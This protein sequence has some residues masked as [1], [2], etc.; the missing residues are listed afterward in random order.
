MR[1]TFMRG[2]GAVLA[3]AGAIL[4]FTR[5]NADDSPVRDDTRLASVQRLVPTAIVSPQ[6]E[7]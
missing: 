5:L 4:I 7:T 1:I 6:R 3:I 2:A